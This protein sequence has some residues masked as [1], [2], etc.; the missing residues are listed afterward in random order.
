MRLH[1]PPTLASWLLES[2]LPAYYRDAMLG[3]LVE[4]YTLQTESTSAFAASLWFWCETC[5]AM[6][7]LM[8][9]S[10]R[11]G[12]L[13]NMGGAAGVYLMMAALKFAADLTISKLFLPRETT[14]VVLAPILFLSTAAI[15][16]CIASRIHRGVTILLAFMVAIT[17][18]VLIV[19]KLC[20]IPV[21][22]WYPIGFLILG[23]LTVVVAAAI[24]GTHKARPAARAI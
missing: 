23:P 24:F 14:H 2:V 5:R 4:E 16:G 12:W 15:G 8:W 7:F 19:I 9:S 22:W 1:S 10:L 13:R 11:N 17:V 21:P 6:P 3:D 20:T 18:M